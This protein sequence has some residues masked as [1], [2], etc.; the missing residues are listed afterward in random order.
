[1]QDLT[2]AADAVVKDAKHD[3]E[4]AGGDKDPA[5]ESST[6]PQEQEAE[7]SQQSPS[8]QPSNDE[9]TSDDNEASTGSD[10]QSSGPKG[11]PA[12]GLPSLPTNPGDA[13]PHH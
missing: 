2:E 12:D 9:Q 13:A 5:A 11:S 6:E 8:S 10:D 3:A 1:V 4:A 7:G